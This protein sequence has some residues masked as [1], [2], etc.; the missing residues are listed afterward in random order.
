[1]EQSTVTCLLPCAR[2]WPNRVCPH[3]LEL[4]LPAWFEQPV[5]AVRFLS[6]QPCTIP[7]L[8][9]ALSLITRS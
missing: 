5:G 3:A 2:R 1:M 8:P 6:E 7:K 9:W 4:A